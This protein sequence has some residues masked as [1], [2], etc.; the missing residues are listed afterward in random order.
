M[1]KTGRFVHALYAR[2]REPQ[3]VDTRT[4]NNSNKLNLNSAEPLLVQIKINFPIYASQDSDER[5]RTQGSS[6]LN[7][8]VKKEDPANIKNHGKLTLAGPA[9]HVHVCLNSFQST[10]FEIMRKTVTLD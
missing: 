4:E 10:K 1:H 9:L 2:G 6:C 3:C 8:E 7:F 5:S